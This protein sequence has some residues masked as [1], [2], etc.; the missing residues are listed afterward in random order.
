MRAFFAYLLISCGVC[1]AQ[2]KAAQIAG[3]TSANAGTLVELR[4]TSDV[5]SAMTWLTVSDVDYKTYE[6]GSVL[7]FATPKPGRY[8]FAL[9]V[10]VVTADGKPVVSI[11]KHAVEVTGAGPVPPPGPR[12]PPGP[13]PGPVP[14]PFAD[15]TKLGSLAPQDNRAAVKQNFRTVATMVVAGTVPSWEQVV[16][17]TSTRNRA[18]LGDQSAP[19]A[20]WNAFLVA[21]GKRLDE[22]RKAGSLATKEQWAAAWNAIAEGL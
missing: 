20:A 11:E 16:S 13:T 21:V 5:S 2:T 18:T 17:E 22:L 3:P 9:V 1:F 14:S 4:A 19:D 12:P 7:V 10:V 8:E 15:L 6:A